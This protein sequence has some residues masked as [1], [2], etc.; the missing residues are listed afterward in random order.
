MKGRRPKLPKRVMMPG[1]WVS[2][3]WKRHLKAGGVRCAGTYEWDRRRL[4]LDPALP[5]AAAWHTYYHEL[6]H[7]ALHDSGTH[8][9]YKGKVRETLCDLAATARMREKFG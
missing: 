4:S 3:R 2:V 8:G 9:R 6:F 5:P 7:A 1:G